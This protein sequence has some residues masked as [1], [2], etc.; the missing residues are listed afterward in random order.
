MSGIKRTAAD[1]AF[2]LMIRERDGWTCRRCGARHHPNSRGLHCAHMFTRRIKATR[3]DP[4]NALALCYGCHSFV[5]A[6][7]WEKAVLFREAL[8][9][10]AFDALAARARGR[11]DRVA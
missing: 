4:E 8:G 1:N 11:R 7:P 6:N 3:H 5:D 2:S 9:D 10:E